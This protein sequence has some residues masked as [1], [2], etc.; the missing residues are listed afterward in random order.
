M[1]GGSEENKKKAKTRRNEGTVSWEPHLGEKNGWK[2]GLT[3]VSTT[4]KKRRE[5]RRGRGTTKLNKG[6]RKKPGKKKS[7]ERR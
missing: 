6:G 7:A 2:K 4:C 1:G 3:Q 5:K